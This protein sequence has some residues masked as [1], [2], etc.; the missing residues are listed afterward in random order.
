MVFGEGGLYG[1]LG[2]GNLRDVEK[3][4]DWVDAQAEALDRAMI[5]QSAREIGGMAAAA[6][7]PCQCEP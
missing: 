2:T 6:R 1:D 3:R 7:R 5:Y 4:S